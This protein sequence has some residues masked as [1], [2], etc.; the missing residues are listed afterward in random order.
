MLK[1]I[2]TKRKNTSVFSLYKDNILIKDSFNI[3]VIKKILKKKFIEVYN[4]RE[5]LTINI[6]G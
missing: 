5:V 3:E 6:E 2:E 1:L 4:S